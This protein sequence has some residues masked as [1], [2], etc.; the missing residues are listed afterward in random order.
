MTH[1][2]RHVYQLTCL[3]SLFCLFV[4]SSYLTLSCPLVRYDVY[5]RLYAYR[6]FCFLSFVY[7]FLLLLFSLSLVVL[8]VTM[9]I[10]AYTPTDFCFLLYVFCFFLLSLSL[11]VPWFDHHQMPPKLLTRATAKCG[12]SPLVNLANLEMQNEHKSHEYHGDPWR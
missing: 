5:R 9:Y 6:L 7:L 1:W 10:G 3:S 4:S 2:E 8:C 12:K 11:L